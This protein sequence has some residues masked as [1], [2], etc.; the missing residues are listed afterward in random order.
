MYLAKVSIRHIKAIEE[1]DIKFS[2]NKYPGWHVFIGDNGA[3]KSSLVRA[4][5]LALFG[6]NEASGLRQD[7]GDW[8]HGGAT[9]GK[10]E[11]SIKPDKHFDKR[12]GSGKYL[13]NYHVG[14]GVIL[15]RQGE[16]EDEKE[17]VVTQAI[18]FRK[19][20]TG[21][22]IDP[23][24]YIWG[25]GKGWFSASFG[26]FRRFQGGNREWE[27]VFYRQPKL[28]AHLSAFGE[29]VALT[30]ALDWLRELNYK[31]LEGKPEGKLLDHIIA[32]VNHGKLLPHDTY[33]KSVSSDG[34]FFIDGNG[35]QVDVNQ[36]SD[37]Y[38]S[39]LSLTFELIRQMTLAYDA[40]QVFADIIKAPEHP[41]ISLPG[42]VLIDEIDAHLHP[43][44]QVRVGQWFTRYFPK[45]QF[46]VTT[47]SPLICRGCLDDQGQ[48][49]GSIYKLSAPGS[50]EKSG[51]LSD[52]ERDRLIYGNVL[53][54]YGTEAFGAHI[55]R[56]QQAQALLKE[57]AQL[58]KLYTFGQIDE[59]QNQRRL[60]LQKIFTTDAISDF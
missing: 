8:L 7:W 6:P 60:F 5:G 2:R 17:Q 25:N 59:A 48:L 19:K 53:D 31:R 55:A 56:A 47:H 9:Q 46:I 40:D 50:G 28:G 10:V 35:N 42:V 13:G 3:G 44:W 37:G 20:D 52:E 21:H 45:L 33:L 23:F 36:M 11:L 54:A 27:K 1:L 49:N 4:I 30:E 39:I 15:R 51:P 18:N 14:A 41:V 16:T 38:R 32:F 43:T 24:S 58:D 12:T 57:Y 29:D 26:P 22:K 34:V